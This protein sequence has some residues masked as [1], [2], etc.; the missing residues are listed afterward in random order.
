MEGR[1]K[2]KEIC[3][4]GVRT[5]RRGSTLAEVA[6]IMWESDCGAVPIVDHEGKPCGII[7]DRDVCMALGTQDRFASSTMV[8]DVV[9]RTTFACSS[10]DD[11]ERALEIMGRE[12]VRRLPVMDGDGRVIG[13]LS[14]NDV[15]LGVDLLSGRGR[16]DP[17]V[18]KVLATIRDVNVHRGEAVPAS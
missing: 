1:M 7:T 10:E 18:R 6:S 9:G 17:L 13:I 5:C 12:Q 14:L 11:I 3:T 16:P 4:P 15:I 2:V 8:Q